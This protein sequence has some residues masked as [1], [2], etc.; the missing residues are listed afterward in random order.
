VIVEDTKKAA[1]EEKIESNRPLTIPSSANSI[2][3]M[4]IE[5][6][7]DVNA[8]KSVLWDLTSGD[9]F[10]ED[11]EAK[12][13]FVRERIA[14]HKRIREKP[15]VQVTHRRQLSSERRLDIIHSL[16][17]FEND[18][19][20]LLVAYMS[21]LRRIVHDTI[22]THREPRH[23]VQREDGHNKRSR[24]YSEPGSEPGGNKRRLQTAP[25]SSNG[26]LHF[27][28]DLHPVIPDLKLFS[29]CTKAD[30]EIQNRGGMLISFPTIW[31]E[32]DSDTI[33]VFGTVTE[34]LG[35]D[36]VPIQSDTHIQCESETETMDMN[37]KLKYPS[38]RELLRRTQAT[39]PTNHPEQ[40]VLQREF[41]LRWM[42]FVQ[43][44]LV[45]EAE[46]DPPW[47]H[48]GLLMVDD[49]VFGDSDYFSRAILASGISSKQIH[50]PNIR[51]NVVHA[52]QRLD[53]QTRCCTLVEYIV[54]ASML[55]RDNVSVFFPDVFLGPISGV[56][57]A[58]VTAFE[59]KIFRCTVEDPALLV[60]S[61]TLRGCDQT[62]SVDET[63]SRIPVH[64]GIVARIK[65]MGSKHGY[66]VTQILDGWPPGLKINYKTMLFCAFV[67][68]KTCTLTSGE[69]YDVERMP[70]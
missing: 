16:R 37:G 69:C 66:S 18:R 19:N 59:Y 17:K 4:L 12:D 64:S 48:G 65:S 32:S 55:L 60:F 45:R 49:C 21:D 23:R 15:V 44:R 13:V 7:F 63:A 61:T 24:S 54:G 3:N 50:A 9:F 30:E 38:M 26:D 10:F 8:A 14:A 22:L 41:I 47:R 5:Q 68:R 52:L 25:H 29:S 2:R 67:V 31:G 36:T 11:Q 1:N 6:G 56:L 20:C 51:T 70:N 33:S 46:K 28:K 35:P 40:K 58:C 39:N 53:V 34:A 42:S 27:D 57:P 62:I 43:H